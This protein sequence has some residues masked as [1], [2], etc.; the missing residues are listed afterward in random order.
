MNYIM[1]KICCT[2][3]CSLCL[4]Q[5]SFA[6]TSVH[7]KDVNTNISDTIIV[8]T[9]EEDAIIE[10]VLQTRVA[11]KKE[12]VEYFNQVTKYGF[13][14]LFSNYSYNASLPYTSQINP[15]AEVFIQDY[16]RG[17]S[18]YLLNMKDWGQP[19]FNLIENVLL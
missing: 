12:K 7:Y 13:K 18:K 11:P 5:F 17:H 4:L 9:V 1:K 3:L 8:D 2:Y 16:M 15:N 10:E 14:N 19:Y 6:G